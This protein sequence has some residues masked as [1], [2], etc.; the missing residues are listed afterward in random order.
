MK[1]LMVRDKAARGLAVFSAIVGL[2]ALSLQTYLT[3]GEFEK[4]GGIPAAAAWRLLGYFTILT[5]ALVAVV[6]INAALRYERRDG[7]GSPRVE[8]ATA[9]AIAMVGL[10]YTLL[11]RA[12]WDPQGANKVADALLHDV[13]PVAFVA[14]FLLRPRPR[15]GSGDVGY[16]LVFPLLYVV[17]ALARGAADGWYA[18]WFL[19]PRNLTVAQ[20][21]LN[22]VGLALCFLAMGVVLAYLSNRLNA[23]T[24][25]TAPFA[26]GSRG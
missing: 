18:Y 20:L 1:M 12:A 17:Y 16:A 26:D 5:N 8:L 14:Y 24:G 22:V 25:G 10:V 11:L 23:S 19:D 9:T 15:L 6:A 4:A 2:A 21:A 7:L 3:L 13:A